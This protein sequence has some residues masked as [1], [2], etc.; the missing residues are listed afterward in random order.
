MSRN[1]KVGKID[2]DTVGTAF[3]LRVTQE[4]VVEVVRGGKASDADLADREVICIEVGGSSEVDLNN[5][6]HHD[7]NEP[8]RSATFQAFDQLL[9]GGELLEEVDD[10]LI[11]EADLISA[12]RFICLVGLVKYI[13]QIDVE[14]PRSLLAYG[15]VKYPTLSDVFSGMLLTE[16]N[17]VEQLYKGIEILKAVIESKQDPFGTISGFDVY[18]KAKAEN[19]KQVTEAVKQAKWDTTASGLRLGFLE[20][21]FYGSVG[22]LYGNGAQVAVVFNPNMNGIRKFTVAGNDVRVDALLPLLNALEPGWG[23]PTT[24]TIIGSPKDGSNL[25]FEEVVEIVKATL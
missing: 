1:V 6:D 10:I 5:Y 11:D 19:N 25:S 21:Q 12:S 18:A 22:A 14:G 20:S 2:L 7:F 8:I 16:R 24:G 3:L 4:D 23:G 13:D 9:N 17:P 15:K